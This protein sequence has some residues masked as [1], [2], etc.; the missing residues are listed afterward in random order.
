MDPIEELHRCLGQ[1]GKHGNFPVL[2]P[3]LCCGTVKHHNSGSTTQFR[4]Q[5][6]SLTKSSHSSV[7]SKGGRHST[8]IHERGG[9]S[10]ISMVFFSELQTTAMA[11]T[12][13]ATCRGDPRHPCMSTDIQVVFVGRFE[14][15]GFSSCGQY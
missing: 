10:Q 3:F 9:Q 4:S 7:G 1:Q 13:V 11:S 5:M 6:I 15:H 2:Q 12:M 14:Y 8:I